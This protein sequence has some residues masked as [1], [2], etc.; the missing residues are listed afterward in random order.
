MSLNLANR[1]TLCRIVA[2]PFFACAVL[3]YSPQQDH[4]RFVALGIFLFA[5]ILDVVDGFVARRYGQITRAGSILDPL[6]DKVLLMSAFVCLYMIRHQLPAVHFPIWFVAFVISRDVILMLGAAVI[7]MVK[8]S[9]HPKPSVW[10]K[11]STVGQAVSI[12]VVLIQWPQT[13]VI[14]FVSA[15]ISAVA[16]LQY[17]RD[18][19]QTLSE[20]SST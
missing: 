18:G 8:G 1:L 19:L 15:G 4:L 7:Q 2:V 11:A 6:A 13:P 14:W 9:L 16:G 10:G 5:V 17:I 20:G 3:Y 12:I